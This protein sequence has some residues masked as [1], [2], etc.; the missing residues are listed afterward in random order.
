MRLTKYKQLK[1]GMQVEARIGDYFASNAKIAIDSDG[2]AWVC[3][4]VTGD[5]SFQW[6]D[7]E[8]TVHISNG[9]DEEWF[10][11]VTL[12]STPQY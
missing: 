10:G 6:F 7:Y 11:G 8:Y 4:N 2:W 9:S 5:S 12:F 1:H 3:Q